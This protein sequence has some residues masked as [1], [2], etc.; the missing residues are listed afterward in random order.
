M[1]TLPPR[2]D[3]EEQC[4]HIRLFFDNLDIPANL[5]VP[6]LISRDQL[7]FIDGTW[8]TDNKKAGAGNRLSEGENFSE[9]ID[10][11]I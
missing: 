11:V 8:L 6:R 2:P 7:R 5:L 3:L 10:A 1:R 4:S 9:G